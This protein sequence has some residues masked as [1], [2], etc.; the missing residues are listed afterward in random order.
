MMGY[1]GPWKNTT[2]DATGGVI[3]HNSGIYYALKSTKSAPNKNFIPSSNPSWWAQVGTI[4][5]TALSGVANPASPR[6]GQVGVY[7][8]NTMTNTMFGP[9]TANGG[10]GPAGAAA[11]GSTQKS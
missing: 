11:L 2:T 9:K 4:G 6:L 7:Y 5:N 8:I 1:L 3:T 10:A